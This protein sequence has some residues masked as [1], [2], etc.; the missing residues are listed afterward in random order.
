MNLNRLWS[1]PSGGEGFPKMQA[2]LQGILLICDNY[3]KTLTQE[4][5]TTI[6]AFT[7]YVWALLGIRIEA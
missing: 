7:T 1:V 4:K 3:G 2:I 6:I 5:Q